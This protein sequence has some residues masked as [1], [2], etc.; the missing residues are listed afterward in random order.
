MFVDVRSTNQLLRPVPHGQ[1]C[2]RVVEE[3]TIITG[4][5]DAPETQAQRHIVTRRKNAELFF[6]AMD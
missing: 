5:Y 4:P 3:N 2:S 6:K 1:P